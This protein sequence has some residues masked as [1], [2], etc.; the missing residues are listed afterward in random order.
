MGLGAGPASTLGDVC[1]KQGRRAKPPR[2]TKVWMMKQ[3][4][5]KPK[6][7]GDPLAILNWKSLA[8]RVG[9]ILLIVWVL[10]ILAG[11]WWALAGAGL[12]T[13]LAAGAIA[14]ALR[15][16]TKTRQVAGIVQGAETR[17]ARQ[18]A[19]AKL[20]ADYKKGDTAAVFAR[21]QLLL[22]E[23][24]RKALSVLE[25]IN[26]DK[27]MA[28]IADETRAQRAMIH[29]LL[30]E[31][32]PARRLVDG[33]ELSRHQQAKTR[34]T[35][36]A[37]VGEAWA[38]TGQAKKAVGIL[39]VIDPEDAEYADLK[40][41]LYRARAFAHVAVNDVRSMR[42]DLQRLG[43]MNP[44]LLGG[45]VAKKV[46]PLLAKEARQQLER[47]GAMPRRMVQQRRRM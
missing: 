21:A 39:D 7:A 12:V 44:Q 42:R 22:H 41:Q 28:P 6:Q 29:L 23:D 4:K 38:R 25:E 47:M 5:V 10:A 40:P 36:T 45:F 13:L 15:F 11:R 8:L 26:L 16:A 2:R 17:E 46:H 19:L 35:L 14:W 43:Q 24:P 33:I 32:E 30:G 3:P 31:T 20:E 27:V 34:A 18:E 37:I 1:M 9:P